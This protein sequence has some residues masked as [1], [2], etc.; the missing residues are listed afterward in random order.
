MSYPNAEDIAWA[1]KHGV[2]P[3][4]NIMIHGLP[5]GKGY[6]GKAHLLNDWTDGCIALTDRE[7]EEVWKLVHDGTP[8]IIYP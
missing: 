2:K 6:I 1:K 5:N 4:G 8:I 3:G 7:I